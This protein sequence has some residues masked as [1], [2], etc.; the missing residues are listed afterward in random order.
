MWILG[1]KGLSEVGIFYSNE[2]ISPV[3]I[4]VLF[5]SVCL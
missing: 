4:R 2:R 1:L 3:L 5:V